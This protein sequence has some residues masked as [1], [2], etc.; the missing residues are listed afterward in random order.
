MAGMAKFFVSRAALVM[1]VLTMPAFA[2]PAPMIAPN[3][4]S[5]KETYELDRAWND[6]IEH[7][8][9]SRLRDR[10]TDSLADI[11][12]CNRNYAG[13]PMCV[14]YKGFASAWYDM[15][16]DPN[17]AVASPDFAIASLNDLGNKGQVTDPLYYQSPQFR[18]T[19]RRLLNIAFSPSR[20]KWGS[21]DQFADHAYKICMEGHYF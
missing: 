13:T 1:G 9:C 21:R 7:G 19:L 2:Q 18:E 5:Q 15:A 17:P 14:S 4:G 12:E 10:R 20:A 3:A 8:A 16:N 11:A 6:R